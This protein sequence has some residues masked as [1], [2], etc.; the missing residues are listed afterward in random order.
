MKQS[1]FVLLFLISSFCFAQA[2]QKDA[3]IEGLKL[4]PN[5]VTADVIYI[6]TAKNSP[7]EIAIFDVLGTKV[8]ATTLLGKGLNVGSLSKGVYI[9]RVVEEEKVATRK[10]IIR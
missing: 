5:P 2:I 10:L 3:D 6:S 9:L 4:Y 8:M 7:K 1:Y